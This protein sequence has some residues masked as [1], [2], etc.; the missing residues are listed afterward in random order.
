MSTLWEFDNVNPRLPYSINQYIREYDISKAN[1]SVLYH[2]GVLKKELYDALYVADKLYR[3]IYIG[4]MELRDPN[5]SVI[6]AEGIKKFRKLFF[7]Y[8]QL[9]DNDIL[10]IKND[11]IFV[12]NKQCAYTK[13][14]NVEFL[15][16]NTYTLFMQ[17]GKLE[18]YYIYDPIT[19]S[20]NIDIKGINDMKLEYHRD[21]IIT[22][23]CDIFYKLQNGGIDDAAK[24]CSQFLENFL[25][26]ELDIGFY[27]EFNDGCMFRCDTVVSSFYLE[28]ADQS[29]LKETF[30]NNGQLQYLLNSDVNFN[31]LRDLCQIVF[32]IRNR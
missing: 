14:D 8:N 19:N 2:E 13:F 30:M 3:E 24:C 27:R 18:I 12:I 16:K 25:R 10:C 31:L 6:K 7:E 11:A 28:Y 20:E 9:E 15:N 23:L 4:K 5:I 26:R 29:L 22:F 17:L 21:H 1:I 32:T